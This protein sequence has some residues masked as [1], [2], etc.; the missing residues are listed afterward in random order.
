MGKQI[1]FD[2]SEIA[3]SAETQANQVIN[4]T[5]EEQIALLNLK[6]TLQNCFDIDAESTADMLECINGNSWRDFFYILPKVVYHV[7]ATDPQL[8][9]VF[10]NSLKCVVETLY[11]IE[12][13]RQTL[14]KLYHLFYDIS[15]KQQ[16]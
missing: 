6:S 13:Y 3:T 16:G 14:G 2:G 7:T 9:S 15:Y 1:K 5:S 10:A 11:D 4:H 12:E 8:G